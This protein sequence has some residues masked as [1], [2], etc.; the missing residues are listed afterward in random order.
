M[1]SF[2][3]LLEKALCQYN[4]LTL[5]DYRTRFVD[6]SCESQYLQNLT[7]GT[8]DLDA[9]YA[10]C[11][12]VYSEF[13]LSREEFKKACFENAG[14]FK[15]SE[16]ADLEVRVLEESLLVGGTMDAKCRVEPKEDVD[17]P[18]E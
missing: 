12:E 6:T 11:A 9:I 5:T 17:V 18:L 4:R 3:K 14:C 15:S 16:E 8:A 10:R 7:A 13:D 2:K 1:G